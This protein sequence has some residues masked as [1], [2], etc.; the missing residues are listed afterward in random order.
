MLE[1]KFSQEP[2]HKMVQLL[3]HFL[4]QSFLQISLQLLLQPEEQ[5]QGEV[6]DLPP[7]PQSPVHLPPQKLRQFPPQAG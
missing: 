6:V 3:P 2:P 5:L 1:Q 4:P 7:D